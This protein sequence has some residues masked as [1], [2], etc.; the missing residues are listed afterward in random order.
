[1]TERFRFLKLPFEVVFKNVHMV[2]APIAANAL[3]LR[4]SQLRL[5]SIAVNTA[6]RARYA[7][8]PAFHRP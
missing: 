5:P 6:K 7:H 2:F 1:V 3:E 4:I 8:L